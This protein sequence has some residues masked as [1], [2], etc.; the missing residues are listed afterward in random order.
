MIKPIKNSMLGAVKLEVEEGSILLSGKLVAMACMVARQATAYLSL[1]S[2]FTSAKVK[3]FIST[4]NRWSFSIQNLNRSDDYLLVI[5]KM[6]LD[7][8][9]R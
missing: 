3:D 7:P 9:K 4:F 5:L 8:S 6:M 1:A 2:L